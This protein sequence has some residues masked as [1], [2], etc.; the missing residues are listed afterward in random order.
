MN[1]VVLASVQTLSVYSY[2]LQYCACM[3]FIITPYTAVY[4]LDALS[5]RKDH[6][7][8]LIPN[9]NHPC[10]AYSPQLLWLVM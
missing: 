3:A 7:L 4:I 2:D 10:N 1:A 8:T 6:V 9:K 5:P